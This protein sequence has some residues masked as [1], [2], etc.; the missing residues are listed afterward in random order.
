MNIVVLMKQVPD[1]AALIQIDEAGT[2]I[3]TEDVKWVINPYDELAIEEAVRIRERL[4]KDAVTVTV[5]SIGPE[6]A[7]ASIRTAFAMGADRGILLNDPA[8]LGANP[9]TAGK[10]LAEAL[11]VIPFD[12]ILAGHRAVDDDCGFVP[13]VVAERLGIPL[14]SMVVREEIDGET[15]R[16][17]HALQDGNVHTEADLPVLLTTQRGLN[18]PRLAT[19]LTIL[20]AKKTPVE[21]KTLADL[22]VVFAPGE[23]QAPGLQMLSL[24][25][26]PTRKAGRIVDGETATAKAR[27]L[28]EL[29][30]DEA[31]VL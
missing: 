8:L 5:L 3:R 7:A 15:I 28:V 29:L 12:L 18:E 4:G 27:R 11:R 16:C 30:M 13:A 31:A 10:A 25:Y 6:S 1:T 23:A 26:P 17:E 24:S 21:M 22:G 19:M 9:L 20:K 14:L 2:G